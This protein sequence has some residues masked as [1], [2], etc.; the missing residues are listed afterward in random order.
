M[1]V[2]VND[3]SFEGLLTSIYDAYYR[4]DNPEEIFKSY[5]FQGGLISEPVFIETNEEKYSKVYESIKGKIGM[6][7]IYTIYYSYLSCNPNIETLIYKYIRL[8]FKLGNKIEDFFHHPTVMSIEK[9]K[10]RVL[11][12]RHRILGFVRF[13][14]IQNKVYY[15]SIEPDNDILALITPHFANR[16]KNNNFI[17][18]DIKRNKCSIYSN[19]EWELQDDCNIDYIKNSSLDEFESLWKTYFKYTNIKERQNL[20]LQKHHMPKRYWKHLIETQQ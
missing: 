17:I 16:F 11:G 1:I 19:G 3:G 9:E 4:K 5:D 13:S 14:L 12:E 15:A 6:N 10:N 20:T 8:G 2:Y 7:A 18:N